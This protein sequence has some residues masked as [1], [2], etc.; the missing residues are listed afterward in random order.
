VHRP[1]QVDAH[2]LR[3]A[4]CVIP[5]ALVGLSGISCAAERLNM[6]RPLPG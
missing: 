5:V 1:E 2:H 6:I 3:D 4:A